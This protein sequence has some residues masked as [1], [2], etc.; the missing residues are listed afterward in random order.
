MI[1]ATFG[2]RKKQAQ[3]LP[4]FFESP[5]KILSANRHEEVHSLLKAAEAEAIAG[6]WVALML[7]YEAAPA[8]DL[9]MK[10]RP[11]SGLPLGWAAVFAAAAQNTPAIVDDEYEVGPWTPRVS[12]EEFSNA[13]SRIRELI[14]AGDT[15]QV[16]FTFPLVAEFKG[17]ARS[18]FRNLCRAQGAEYCAY[19]DLGRY[20][21]LSVSPELFF[22]LEGRKLTTRPMKG[23]IGRGRWLAEDVQMAERLAGSAKDRAENVM[24][25][26]LLRND[27]GRVATAGSVNVK[28]LFD[29]ERYETLWQMT[30]TIEGYIEIRC[31]F[32]GTDGEVVSLRFNHGRSQD[33]HDGNHS[34]SGSFPARRLHGNA[35]FPETRRLSSFQCGDSHDHHRLGRK[36]LQLLELAAA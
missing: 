31:R 13:I 22:E 2:S 23:T 11:A 29:L 18:W 26:D 9:A 21:V 7:S 19:F 24:I 8:F 10:T 34:R 30:S 14:A 6:H 5:L 12:R 33:S 35:R 4:T 27:V 3:A 32:C 17:D 1:E 20:K 25:V 36:A 16:N 15:Y 28:Q